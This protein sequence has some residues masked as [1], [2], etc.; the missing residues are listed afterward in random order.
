MSTSEDI[1]NAV[2][3]AFGWR[4]GQ[5]CSFSLLLSYVLDAAI[6]PA[7]A[8]ESVPPSTYLRLGTLV[9]LYRT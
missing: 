2:E 4:V 3:D 7:I 5:V 1:V 9:Q 6:Y 8:A